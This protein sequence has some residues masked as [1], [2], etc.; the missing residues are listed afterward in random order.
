MRF[1]WLELGVEDVR[2]RGSYPLVRWARPLA[3]KVGVPL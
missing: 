3:S 1:E 2:M